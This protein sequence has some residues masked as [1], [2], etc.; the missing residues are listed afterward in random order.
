MINTGKFFD[1]SILDFAITADTP[2]SRKEN[3]K[4]VYDN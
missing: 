3:D 2:F 4:Q 1:D